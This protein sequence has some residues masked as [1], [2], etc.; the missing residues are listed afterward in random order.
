MTTS[1][2]ISSPKPNHQSVKVTQG[3]VKDGVFCGAGQYSEVVLGD[4]ES[5]VVYVHDGAAFLV[6]EVPKED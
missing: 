3:Y 4:G 6:T 2:V 5:T 1:V